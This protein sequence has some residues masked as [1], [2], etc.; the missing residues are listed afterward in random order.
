MPCT[1][2]FRS[3]DNTE[4]DCP[5][6][7]KCGQKTHV[8]AI[9]ST[10]SAQCSTLTEWPAYFHS[11][12][13][14]FKS[15]DQRCQLVYKYKHLSGQSSSAN[16]NQYSSC[17]QVSSC[18]KSPTA[19]APSSSYVQ[20]PVDLE[21]TA[22]YH[23]LLS[24]NLPNIQ[25]HSEGPPDQSNNNPTKSCTSVSSQNPLI[26]VS[27]SKTSQNSPYHPNPLTSTACH[28]PLVS[29]TYIPHNLIQS[30]S[31]MPYDPVVS[32][33]AVPFD[34]IRNPPI[35]TCH[36]QPFDSIHNSPHQPVAATL[37]AAPRY[38]DYSPSIPSWQDGISA[39]TDHHCSENLEEV[40]GDLKHFTNHASEQNS[41]IINCMDLIAD[42]LSTI[43]FNP[44]PFINSSTPSPSSQGWANIPPPAT[45][46][47]R[48]HWNSNTDPKIKYD[49]SEEDDHPDSPLC[50][51][52]FPY[53]GG[54]SHH[55]ASQQ[56]L[57]IIWQAMRRVGM[58]SFRPSLGKPLT[59][60]ENRLCW[61]FS[62]KIFLKLVSCSKY[63]GINLDITN[64]QVIWNALQNH[65]QH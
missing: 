3:H 58:Q 57:K 41:K 34:S 60:P 36:S 59:I 27:T 33:L 22:N 16:Q 4:P 43:D 24:Q 12:N 29:P 13:R 10:N 45:P 17:T 28:K 25:S 6:P 49:S 40:V 1:P 62:F 7:G 56:T 14:P 26:P 44:L 61:T 51:P 23:I 48:A 47:D 2:S 52:Q 15:S 5:T 35:P 37:D 64:E 31:A 65:V 9:A 19:N 21:R 53:P 30:N 32:T 8:P 55:E 46:E 38:L 11:Q 50:D 18:D 63:E 54:S 42:K 39:P 20:T